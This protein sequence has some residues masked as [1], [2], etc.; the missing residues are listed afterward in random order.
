[1]LEEH[2]EGLRLHTRLG[3]DAAQLLAGR[4]CKSGADTDIVQAR[5]RPTNGHTPILLRAS[6]ISF[7]PKS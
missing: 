4:R 3:R 2:V 6:K 1:M 7:V 5:R